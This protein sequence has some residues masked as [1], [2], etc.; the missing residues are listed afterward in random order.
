MS[1][2]SVT[3]ITTANAT[4]D[5]TLRSGNSSGAGIIVP[6]NGQSIIFQSNSSTNSAFYIV[7]N[8]NVGIGTTS[9]DVKL[10]IKANNVS[11]KGQIVLDSADY[12]QITHYNG[13]NQYGYWYTETSGANGGS[14]LGTA[15]AAPLS[16]TTS[17]TERMRID[18]SGRVTMPFMPAFWALGSGTQSWSGAATPTKVSFSAGSQYVTTNKSAGWSQANSR[19]TAPV[20]GT[21]EFMLSFAVQ[22]GPTT[23]PAAILYKNGSAWLEV[24][25]NYSSSTYNQTTGNVMLDLNANDYVEFWITN[26]NNVSFTIDL[27][28]CKFSGKLIG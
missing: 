6:A 9:P 18:S 20:A 23:G 4:T 26:Y 2:L 24:L 11:A 12:S 8:G 27:G 15:T 14:V 16:F 22:T 1:T 28:R 25:I 3:T 13:A 19:Y 10:R 5:L 21:Y 7:A 17:S